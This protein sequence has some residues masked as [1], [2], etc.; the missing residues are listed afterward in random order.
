MVC[1]GS[2]TIITSSILKK[3]KMKK[4]EGEEFSMTKKKTTKEPKEPS[5]KAAF[6]F[7]QYIQE[8]II[9]SD[10]EYGLGFLFYV[11]NNNL[12]FKSTE[13]VDK[14]YNKFKETI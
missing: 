12:T 11:Y 5:K 2:N 3:R 4:N 14:E 10:K 1:Y 8:T 9:P 13:E 7:E 6:D